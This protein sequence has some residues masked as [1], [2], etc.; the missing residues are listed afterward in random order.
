MP[1]L[2]E[3]RFRTSPHVELKQLGDLEEAQREAFRELESDPEFYGLFVPRAPLQMNLKAVPRQTADVFRALANPAH[4]DDAVLGD[5]SATADVIDLVLDR[6]LEVESGDGFVS[7]ADALPLVCPASVGGEL[8]DALSRNALLHAQHLETTDPRVLT[9]ALY[10]YNRIPITPFWK[11]RFPDRDAVLAHLGAGRGSLRSLLE[12]DW[13]MSDYGGVWISW[14]WKAAVHRGGNDV[15][16]KLYVS[17]RPERMRDAFEVAVRVLS[18]FPGTP[19]KIG[20]DAAGLLRPDKMVAYFPTRELLNEVAGE[21][22]RE[23]AG[24]EAHGVPFS[25]AF[26]ENMLLS[27]GV[28]PPDTERALRWLGR[29]SWRSWLAQRLGAALSAAK[30]ARSAGAV[31]PWR[32]AVERVCRHGVDTSTWTPTAALWSST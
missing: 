13:T 29:D 31:E 22:R 14:S 25:A 12:R 23:L 24:C 30:S 18:N 4:L 17:P 6:I 20:N 21:L 7:G 2:S 5:A 11:T 26:D 15:T 19:F 10:H 16:Y 8:R 27:W 3:I 9:R 32:F 1:A 28:D